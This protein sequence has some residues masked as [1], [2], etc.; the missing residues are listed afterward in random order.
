MPADTTRRFLVQVGAFHNPDRARRMCDA[1]AAKG[2]GLA[3]SSGR[4]TA[5]NW[6]FCRS[7]SPLPKAEAL[8]MAQR[9]HD[10]ANSATVL[11]PVSAPLAAAN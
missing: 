10:E 5:D 8:A 11:V 2:F 7:A 3:V 6:H 9:L 1:L 4:S